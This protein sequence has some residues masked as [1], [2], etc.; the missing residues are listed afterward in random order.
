MPT[1]GIIKMS[2]A[3][4]EAMLGNPVSLGAGNIRQMAQKST[5]IIKM[6]DLY[7]KAYGSVI[8]VKNYQ[9]RYNNYNG[10]VEPSSMEPITAGLGS[11]KGDKVIN[12]TN[13]RI[14]SFTV[15]NRVATTLITLGKVKGDSFDLSSVQSVT[16]KRIDNGKTVTFSKGG[17]AYSV[18]DLGVT[19]GTATQYTGLMS[20]SDIDK[21]V[22]FQ[23]SISL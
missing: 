6:S 1:S 18:G 9:D 13:L 19:F 20:D 4:D 2:Q 14:V 21:D 11:I 10:Y 8:T 15:Y 23:V 3:R 16:I 7:S 5:G 12:K 22:V 17:N